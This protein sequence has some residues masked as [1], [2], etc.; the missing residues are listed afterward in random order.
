MT[1]TVCRVLAL[2]L[3]A[4]PAPALSIKRLARF[5]HQAQAIGTR[6]RVHVNRLITEP[7]TLELEIGASISE[8]GDNVNPALLKFAPGGDDLLIGKTEYSVGFDYAHTGNDITANANSLLYDGEHWNVTLGP[9]VTFLR[10]SGSG[11]RAGATLVTR[12]DY[13]PASLGV[14][15]TWSKATRPDANTPADYA[16]FGAGGGIRLAKEGR[17]SHFTLNANALSEHASSSAPIYSAFEGIEWEI[18]SHVSAN[19]T[20]QQIDIRG[21]NR[22]NQLFLGFTINFGRLKLH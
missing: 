1:P 9:N 22:D 4:L 12:Y 21:P 16:A 8:Y 11:L 2:L 17:L 14:T 19:L 13:G 5:H 10:Q 18:T 15:A 7:G 3:L 20:V 6:N